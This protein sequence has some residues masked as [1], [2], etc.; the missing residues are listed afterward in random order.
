MR[1]LPKLRR[2]VL[3]NSAPR[4]QYPEITY[5]MVGIG[6][7]IAPYA[8]GR[9]NSP[10]SYSIRYSC[11]YQ[12]VDLK[13]RYGQR[14]GKDAIL[15]SPIGGFLSSEGAYKELAPLGELKR[16]CQPFYAR[17]LTKLDSPAVKLAIQPK[18]ALAP[19]GER[20]STNS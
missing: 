17:P 11:T 13:V 16:P 4:D 14:A 18:G 7:I 9:L 15:A 2:S 19:V 1:A 6:A 10:F 3:S 5:V 8:E 20:S 12:K